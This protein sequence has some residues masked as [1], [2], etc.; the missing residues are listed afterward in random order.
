MRKRLQR[1]RQQ[2]ITNET[3]AFCLRML[4][5][6]L[7]ISIFYLLIICRELNRKLNCATQEKRNNSNSIYLIKNILLLKFVFIPF[8][9][10]FITLPKCWDNFKARMVYTSHY[11]SLETIAATAFQYIFISISSSGIRFELIVKQQ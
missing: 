11:D 3:D 5:I 10:Y 2:K 4:L 1:N 9:Q 8:S 7:I 6:L